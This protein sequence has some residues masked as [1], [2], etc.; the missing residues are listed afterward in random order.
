MFKKLFQRL[1]VPRYNFYLSPFKF[2]L[3]GFNVKRGYALDSKRNI[4]T[5]GLRSDE[6][7]IYCYFL[8]KDCWEGK[9]VFPGD[10]INEAIMP[11]LIERDKTEK[12]YPDYL[13]TVN[14]LIE[15]DFDRRFRNKI[16]RQEVE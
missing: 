1:F 7:A 15:F 5:S 6:G 2:V 8:K 12:T 3:E 14:D 16:E 10:P 9:W 4:V 11:L 13:P